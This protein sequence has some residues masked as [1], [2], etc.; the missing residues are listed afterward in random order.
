MNNKFEKLRHL[1]IEI[2]KE[3]WNDQYKRIIS[4][5]P[6]GFYYLDHYQTP[7]ELRYALEMLYGGFGLCRFG[8]LS[9]MVITPARRQEKVN[10]LAEQ[11]IQ[12]INNIQRQYGFKEGH[13]NEF[14]TQYFQM[15][16][17]TDTQRDE[18]QQYLEQFLVE[19]IV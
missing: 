1:I 13:D 4:P 6:T 17:L 7:D 10:Q 5:W 9:D 2:S 14:F 8:S 16:K 15:H 3:V 12:E 19:K 18:H 11:A